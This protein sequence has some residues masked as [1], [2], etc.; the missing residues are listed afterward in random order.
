MSLGALVITAI[1]LQRGLSGAGFLRR[2]AYAMF[3]GSQLLTAAVLFAWII[4]LD[5]SASMTILA[6]VVVLACCPIDALL[7][8]KLRQAQDKEFS[9]AR[10]EMLAEQLEIQ[11]RYNAKLEEDA[12]NIERVRINAQRELE[13]ASQLLESSDGDSAL[14]ALSGVQEVMGEAAYRYCDN[15][16]ID[17][18]VDVK[19]TECLQA[20]VR[21]EFALEVPRRTPSIPD[22]ELCAVFSN[23][24]DNALEA[25]RGSSECSSCAQPFLVVASEVHGNML[26]I[27]THNSIADASSVQGETINKEKASKDRAGFKSIEDHGWDLSIVEEIAARHGGALTTQIDGDAFHASVILLLDSEGSACSDAA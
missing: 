3:P 10:V 18:I 19:R 23:L 2:A 16:I 20:G 9:E 22:V 21:A 12:K 24:I 13:R 11:K 17:V 6:T 26:I 15:P 25:A 27:S 1:A 4:A 5:L 7:F 14:A 8:R